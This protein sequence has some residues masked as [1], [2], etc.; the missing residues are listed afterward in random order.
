MA[1][2]KLGGASSPAH[3]G[4]PD[5]RRPA[6][7][8]TLNKGGERLLAAARLVRNFVGEVDQL[9]AHV[10]VVQCLVKGVAEL[11][12]DCFRRPFGSKQSEPRK[13]LE[14][15]HPGFL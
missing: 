5:D 11:I 15:R 9:F 14:L 13:Y 3:S 10:L 4:R 7:N 2:T 6:S 12:E 1:A 8:L